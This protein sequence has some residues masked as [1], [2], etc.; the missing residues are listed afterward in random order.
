VNTG[1]YT[2]SGPGREG[3]P[4]ARAARYTFVYANRDGKW[5]IVDHHS[6]FMPAP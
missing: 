1:Y 3:L 6:S 5:M 4:A 2:F